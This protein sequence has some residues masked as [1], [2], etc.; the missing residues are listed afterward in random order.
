MAR[1]KNTNSKPHMK[2]METSGRD[3]APLFP[4]RMC[5]RKIIPH[6]FQC[7]KPKLKAKTKTKNKNLG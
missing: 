2:K 5:Q 6:N 3:Q 7:L 4:P 1:V